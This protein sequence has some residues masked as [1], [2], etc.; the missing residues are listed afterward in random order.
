MDKETLL[1]II[2]G[3]LTL[4]FAVIGFI[5]RD[6]ISRDKEFQDETKK[7]DKENYDHF[8]RH[9]SRMGGIEGW[10]KLIRNKL[11]LKDD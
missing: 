6:H 3:L 11:G 5:V 1:L 8:H 7:Q 2:G 9:S 4:L 10:V